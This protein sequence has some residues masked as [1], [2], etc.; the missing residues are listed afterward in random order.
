MGEEQVMKTQSREKMCEFCGASFD[1]MLP[2]CPYCG[3]TNI[4][5]AEAAYMDK[6]EEVRS[7]L[8]ELAQ[9]PV[10]ETKKE[11]KKQTKLIFSVIGAILV[12]FFVLTVVKLISENRY[13]EKSTQKKQADFLWKQEN[14]DTFDEVYEQGDDEKLMEIYYEAASEG[15]PVYEWGHSD[16]SFALAHYKD[17]EY[18]WAKIERGEPPMS[19]SE[20]A[21]LLSGYFFIEYYYNR[22]TEEEKE[23]FSPYYEKAK[24][25]YETRWDFQGK[26]WEAVEKERAE[27]GG[28]ISYETS[29]KY[30]E[31]WLK[32]QGK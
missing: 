21:G 26:E 20:Y 25:D 6:L 14:L 29:E 12:V 23:R 8:E 3:N 16:Y 28:T 10:E 17:M 19:V 9:I 13:G 1:E 31:A 27:H 15:K 2:K 4:K 5:G 32:R 18:V 11:I 24:A 7:D 22:M 30:V